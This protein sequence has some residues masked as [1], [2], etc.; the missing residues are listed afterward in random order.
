[1]G[2][3]DPTARK[4]RFAREEVARWRARQSQE[5]LNRR[6]AADSEYHRRR[7]EGETQEEGQNRLAFL[8][9]CRERIHLVSVD[10]SILFF[11]L[12]F[13]R[14]PTGLKSSFL[15]KLSKNFM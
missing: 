13:L 15:M 2:R 10:A 1:M 5:S 14:Y 12:Y 11:M 9:E 6:H 3:E 4:G 8:S 7:R